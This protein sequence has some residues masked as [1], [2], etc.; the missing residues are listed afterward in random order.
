[1]CNRAPSGL[2]IMKNRAVLVSR[3][4]SRLELSQLQCQRAYPSL[5]F[6]SSE[7]PC[8]F[9]AT[10]VIQTGEIHVLPF[11]VLYGTCLSERTDYNI[12]T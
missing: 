5:T 7:E 2:A 9:A 11:S 4:V 1:M 8:L 3:T 10:A 12:N 6:P